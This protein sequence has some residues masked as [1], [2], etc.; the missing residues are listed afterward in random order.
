[1]DEASVIPPEQESHTYRLA[2]ETAPDCIELLR[3]LVTIPSPSRGERL[4][5]ERVMREMETLGYRDVHLD[6]MG[7][8]LGRFGSGPRVLAVDAHVDT[9]GISNPTHWKYDPFRGVVSGGILY[10]RG[11]SDQKGGLA[12]V[13][14]GVAL[15]DRIGLPDDLT[16]WVTATVNGEDC[17]GLAWRYIVNE[18]DL[19]PEVV[20][21]SMPSHLGVCFGQRGR[22]EIQ[23]A[24]RGVSTH[25][26][27]PD[28]GSNA[29]YAMT[30][31]VDELAALH[32][33][34][35]TDHPSLGCGSIAVTEIVSQSPSRTAIPDG[36][37]IHI[38]RR[39]TIGET[40]DG[41][42]DE[43]RSLAAVAKAEAEVVL[44][45]YNQPSWRGFAYP[46][47]KV[48]PAWVTAADSAA[49]QAAMAAARTV[50]GREPRIHRSKF[51]SS[52]CTTAGVF[53]IPTV[54]FGPADELHS[55]TVHDQIALAQLQPAMAFYAMFPVFYLA[56]APE[57]PER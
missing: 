29:I 23:V 43:I 41:A 40:P 31:I 2:E 55:H 50:L 11:A 25:G 28:R 5:C 54:G 13:V 24:T 19:R 38:D 51:S 9:V 48:F 36:C 4:A 6:E 37:R 27:Q 8:V 3:D 53:G 32:G 33:R 14:H 49:V 57:A 30:P 17:V 21:V 12:A 44:L 34:L 22:M 15:A 18:A 35:G 39:L 1:M 47:E 42:L 56:A 16:V 10:G 46:T 20:V 45:D 7:N 52:G 26:S